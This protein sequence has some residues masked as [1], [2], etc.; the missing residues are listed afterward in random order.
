MAQVTLPVREQG[1]GATSRR[2][3]WWLGPL[4]TLL[5][6]LAFLVYANYIVFFVPGYFEIR[7][8]TADFFAPDNP[9]VAPYLAPFHSPLIYDEQSPHR[10]ITAR[11]PS[12]WPSWSPLVFSSAM[13]ILIF[14]AGFRL[15][16]YY[17]R[18]AY[19]RAF[20]ADPPACA[21]GEPRKT[22]WGEN[23]WPLLFQNIHRY[24][25]Y[26]ALVILLFLAWDALYAFYWPVV[27]GNRVVGHR[28]GMG[29]GTLIMWVNVVLLAGFTFGCNS[30]RH[31][32]GGRLDCFSCPNNVAKERAGYRAWRLVSWFN[33]RHMLWAW[34]SLFSVGFADFY[35]RMCAAGYWHDVRFF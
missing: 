29:L 8:N 23:H 24:F 6:L 13:L 33:E 16:C 30:L 19:Y 31:L 10:W 34:L 9:A 20:W 18:K 11:Q 27:E 14:P 4:L 17:Y 1:F 21:V 5:G 32:V 12:W 2:D 7:K 35:I 26:A 28:L 25:L 15:T 22:Y 3:A